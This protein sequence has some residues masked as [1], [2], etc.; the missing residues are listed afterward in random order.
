MGCWQLDTDWA[1]LGSMLQG[2]SA[3]AMAIAAGLGVKTWWRQLKATREQGLAEEVLTAAYRLV[4]AIRQVRHPFTA[5]VELNA[6]ERLDIENDAEFE[7]RKPYATVEPRIQRYLKDDFV[8]LSALTFKVQAVLG[9]EVVAAI[10]RLLNVPEKLRHVAQYA[11]MTAVHKARSEEA[12]TRLWH[13]DKAWNAELQERS[14]AATRELEKV[15]GVLWASSSNDGTS[16]E[17]DAAI[18]EIERHL[19]GLASFAKP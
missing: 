12:L 17:I 15:S 10:Q 1:A 5:A 18:R 7:A 16:V 2:V 6:V 19:K 4:D 8:Q 9:S 13:R 14:D 11:S 3:V